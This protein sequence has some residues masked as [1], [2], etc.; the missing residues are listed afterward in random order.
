MAETKVKTTT[1]KKVEKKE[2]K[3][4][5]RKLN[6]N[7][8]E[9]PYNADLVAQVLY[10]YNSNERK[11]TANVKGRSEVSGGGRKPWRQKGT[12]R[13]RAGSS[14]SPLWIG[15]GVTFGNVG[16]RNW[17]RKINKKM[18]RKATCIMLSEDLRNKTLEFTDIKKDDVRKIRENSKKG[19]SK[20]VLVVTDK[21]DLAVKIRNVEGVSI[22]KPEKLNAKHIVANR[23]VYVDNGVIDTLEKRLTNDK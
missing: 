22:V 11:S 10:V 4:E 20:K 23:L 16:D 8:W 19:V 21:E 7:V 15:G 17:N 13:A 3:A 14:R 9:V 2:E 1:T 6:P 12:G 18:A 5:A